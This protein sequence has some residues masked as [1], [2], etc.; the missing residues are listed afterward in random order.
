MPRS[1]SARRS[2]LLGGCLRKAVLT[3]VTLIVALAVGLEMGPRPLV[4]GGPAV[5][6]VRSG[7]AGQDVRNERAR[8]LVHDHHC[9]TNNRDRPRDM[10]D[11]IP[12]HVVVTPAPTR[13]Q[14]EPW[15]RYSRALVQPALGQLFDDQPAQ[16]VVHAFCR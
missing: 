9:W 16:L 10:R 4:L 1:R 6:Q 15:P 7:S 14:H 11:T 3:S 8:D 12:G 5:G 13:A 2:Q